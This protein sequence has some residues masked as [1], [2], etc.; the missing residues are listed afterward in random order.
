MG[1]GIQ[2]AT[3]WANETIIQ[4][5]MRMF[6][7][8]ISEFGHFC[9]LKTP[10]LVRVF[11]VWAPG[12]FAAVFPLHFFEP[13]HDTLCATERWEGFCSHRIWQSLWRIDWGALIIKVFLILIF[14]A[15]RRENSK[16]KFRGRGTLLVGVAFFVALL[17]LQSHQLDLVLPQTREEPRLYS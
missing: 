13:C 5:G 2:T 10:V 12:Q 6:G 17:R 1:V 4:H 15:T 9:C 11:R 8:N 16:H 3:S 14:F 7:A